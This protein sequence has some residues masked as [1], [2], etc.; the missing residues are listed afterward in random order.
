MR[1]DAE[2]IVPDL[3]LIDT[4]SPGFNILITG[5]RQRLRQPVVY[6]LGLIFYR[7]SSLNPR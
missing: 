2:I 5:N 6:P 3:P 7:F 4:D 1:F